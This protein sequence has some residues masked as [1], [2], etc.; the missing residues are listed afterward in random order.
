ME[1]NNLLSE[2][3]SIILERWFDVI[4]ETY[5]ADTSSFL[6]KQK[7]QFTNPVGYTIYQ[8]IEGIFEG[9][10]NGID[11]ERVSPFLDG[12]IRI[13]AVQDFTP[14]Q[15]ISFIFLLKKVIRE[16]LKNEI[17]EDGIAEEL[18][19]LESKIDELAFL[20]FDIYM[21]CREK[22]YEL[23]ANEVRNMTFRLLQRANLIL[24]QVQDDPVLNS[25]EL[26]SGQDNS[27]EGQKPNFKDVD[28]IVNLK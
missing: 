8:G 2:K 6:K 19:E 20:S 4:L 21:K 16:E 28:D 5:P 27:G 22:I 11:S 3:R 18:L 10:L 13:R 15:A 25:P 9:L 24:N 23:K 17:G 14:S 26:N 12:I 1:L 7:N